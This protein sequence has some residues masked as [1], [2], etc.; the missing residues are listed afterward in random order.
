M[1]RVLK[2]TGDSLLPEYQE[3]DF[4]LV[5][6]IPFF[7]HGLAVGD[8]IVFKHSKLGMLIKRIDKIEAHGAEIFVTG[9]HPNSMDSRSF[10]FVPYRDVIGKVI[11]HIRKSG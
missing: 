5:V 7:L 1:F 4:V 9:T 10:G 2:V 11:W 8:I 6:K 3:G